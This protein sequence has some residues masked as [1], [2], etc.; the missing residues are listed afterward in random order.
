MGFWMCVCV[1]VCVCVWERERERKCVC[2]CVCVC[3]RVYFTIT[4]MEVYVHVLY[5]FALSIGEG[6]TITCEFGTNSD[7]WWNWR[8]R[9]QFP[10]FMSLSITYPAPTVR[11]SMKLG[12]SPKP[13]STK[14][15]CNELELEYWMLATLLSLWPVLPVVEKDT[16]A[17]GRTDPY[18]WERERERGRE[19]VQGSVRIYKKY[20]YRLVTTTPHF[21][22]IIHV[23][24]HGIADL[25]SWY[26]VLETV[27]T[28]NCTS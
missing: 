3:E 13:N 12:V 26:T 8:S 22:D 16:V 25:L 23:V 15:S 2:V 17:P 19:V 6:M 11:A 28:E 1:C 9:V 7:H 27:A 4:I 14:G 24:W 21:Y 18:G 20:S 5:L 10:F